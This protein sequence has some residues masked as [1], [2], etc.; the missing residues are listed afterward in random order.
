MNHK[1]MSV[2]SV[3]RVKFTF[4]FTSL[5]LIFVEPHE[6]TSSHSVSEWKGKKSFQ[7]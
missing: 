2:I 4:V 1:A 6:K 7:S 5:A 3:F